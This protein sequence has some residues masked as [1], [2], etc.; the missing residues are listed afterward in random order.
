MKSGTIGTGSRCRHLDHLRD[1]SWSGD[2]QSGC[3]FGLEFFESGGSVQQPVTCSARGDAAAGLVDLD[4]P[5][6][7]PSSLLMCVASTELILLVAALLL[8]KLGLDRCGPGRMRGVANAG[9]VERLLGV[10]RLR[11][12]RRM[13]RPD[14]D[15]ELGAGEGATSFFESRI[16]ISTLPGS[17][18]VANHRENPRTRHEEADPR[19][20]AS[21]SPAPPMKEARR[22]DQRLRRRAGR[23]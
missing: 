5:I 21:G 17:F 2:R 10:I 19:P 11:R 13:V 3:R 4:G 16:V 9:E 1:A 7:S 14:L 15:R 18:G 8:L 23:R 22:G 12:N 6:A 20:A